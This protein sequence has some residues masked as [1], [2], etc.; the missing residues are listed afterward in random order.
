MEQRRRCSI[1]KLTDRTLVKD[2][3]SKAEIEALLLL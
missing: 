1:G 2:S 3:S